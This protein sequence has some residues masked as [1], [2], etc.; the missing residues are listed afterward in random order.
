MHF[1]NFSVKSWV[2]RGAQLG[3]WLF[4]I[5]FAGGSLSCINMQF[6]NIFKSKIKW[7]IIFTCSSWKV[8]SETLNFV[9]FSIFDRFAICKGTIWYFQSQCDIYCLMFFILHF[10]SYIWDTRSILSFD[11]LLLDMIH[12]HYRYT[13]RYMINNIILQ[14][15]TLVSQA[16][17]SITSES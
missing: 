14:M 15:D 4:I 1:C 8:S 9:S 17:Y 16:T 2:W 11:I 13:F 3:W 12:G 10:V 5:L 7:Q 6:E